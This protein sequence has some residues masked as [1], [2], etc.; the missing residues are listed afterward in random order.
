MSWRQTWEWCKIRIREYSIRYAKHK[1]K[2]EKD[3]SVL[4]ERLLKLFEKMW[5]SKDEKIE[6]MVKDYEKTTE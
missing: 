4:E 3:V 1:K 6:E 2:N 5:N